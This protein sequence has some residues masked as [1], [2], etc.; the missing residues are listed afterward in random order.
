MTKM[1][2]VGRELRTKYGEDTAKFREAMKAWAKENDYPRGDVRT[3]VD[4]IEHAV[5]LAG[6]DGVGL[7][8]DFDGIGKT[9]EWLSDVSYYPYITQEL[10][11]R[12]Y[13]KADILKILG[14]NAFRV[15]KEA[16]EVAAKLKKK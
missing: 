6:I 7:G 5:K 14:G 15:L 4:H 1:F 8:S 3:V 16:E 2:D 13:K 11:N 9:P 10:L 12:G